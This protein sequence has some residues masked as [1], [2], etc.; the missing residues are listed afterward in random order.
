MLSIII[1]H[2]KSPE[3]L[4]LCLHYLKKNAPE[5]AEIIVTDSET[6][7][8]TENLMRCEF[9]QVKF[10]ASKENIGFAKSVNRGI[11]HAKGDFFL[12]INADVII[13]EKDAIPKM[14]GAM[15]ENADI[16][17][18][19]PKLLSI[20][21]ERQ[22]SCFRFYS[23][24]TIL[25]RRTPF[26]KTGW[27]KK[28]LERFLIELPTSPPA[29]LLRKERGADSN[30][31]LTKG[32]EGGSTIPV[33]WLMGSA[34]LVRKKAYQEVGPLDERYF[35]YMEDVDWCRSFWQK[36]WKVVYDPQTFFYHYHF[37]ASKKG[38]ALLGIFTNKYARTHLISAWK[39]FRKY[40]L[41]VPRYGV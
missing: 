27:G 38:G 34:L 23:P 3:V 7:E 18:L 12:I 9:P 25:A 24:L 14:L 8:K 2:H 10:L 19:G 32:E 29:P 5:D 36:G 40:R 33:D 41:K 15:Q 4:K 28:E 35:M 37:Q 26:G 30:P 39:Y 20:N 6:I 21:D 22:P 13:S 1:N 17:I 11:L 16:G 31:P